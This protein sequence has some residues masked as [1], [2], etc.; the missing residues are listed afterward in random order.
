MSFR[1]L[2]V[3]YI[4]IEEPLKQILD[5]LPELPLWLSIFLSRLFKELVFI[6][7]Q[8]VSLTQSEP[9]P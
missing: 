7:D 2:V 5:L 6:P 8:F 3:S 4:F 1:R 9:L